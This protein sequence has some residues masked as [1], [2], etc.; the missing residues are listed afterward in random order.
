MFGKPVRRDYNVLRHAG[1]IYSIARAEPYW[2]NDYQPAC[3][4]ALSYLWAKYTIPT[5][6]GDQKL[7][8][9]ASSRPG[10][11][12]DKIVKLGGQAL[13]IVS[14]LAQVRR[15]NAF[16]EDQVIKLGK[17]MRSMIHDTG[18]TISKIDVTT[19]VPSSFVSLY[20][21]GEAA[22]AFVMLY[23]RLGCTDSLALATNV[24]SYLANDRAR[25]G[26]YP[27]D[28][29][30]LIATNELFLTFQ[31]LGD[32]V[33]DLLYWHA[34]KIVETILTSAITA[35][36]GS[37]ALTVKGSIC[38]TA[39]WI[40]GLA[41]IWPW[42]RKRNYTNIHTVRAFVE[43][44]SEYLMGAQIKEGELKGGLPWTSPKH[45]KFKNIRAAPEVRIDSVQHA[46]C[47]IISV[48]ELA[49]HKEAHQARLTRLD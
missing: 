46:L 1:A 9:I 45:R 6:V 37:G 48:S 25:S 5:Q 21:P 35:A 30:A 33:R 23:Q 27:P 42:L 40:E 3:D 49:N 31:D 13:A 20:Y 28:H 17:Y 24:L 47:G 32:D 44:G 39:T 36:D 43:S 34:V 19:N 15:L 11:E 29:W 14:L 38:G 12:G 7:L 41:A 4:S 2:D 22:L 18:N 10:H 16:E 8:G 26:E